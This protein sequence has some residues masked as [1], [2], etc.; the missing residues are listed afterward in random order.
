MCDK[1]AWWETESR[2]YV[3][4]LSDEFDVVP[5]LSWYG[6]GYYDISFAPDEERASTVKVLWV[7]PEC[8]TLNDKEAFCC[9]GCHRVKPL[10]R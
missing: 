6:D 1:K 4:D 2:I 10:I 8:D 5:D 7:C 9:S 3:G